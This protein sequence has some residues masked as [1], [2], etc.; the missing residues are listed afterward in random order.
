MCCLIVSVN[1]FL[2]FNAFINGSSRC[3]DY[4]YSPLL[5]FGVGDRVRHFRGGTIG[6]R[7][8]VVSLLR[9]CVDSAPPIMTT[10]S[11]VAGVMQSGVG[12]GMVRGTGAGTG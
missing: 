7:R 2:R 12:W 1:K 3:Y 11:G 9:D 4:E 8:P 6:R 10:S 5:V